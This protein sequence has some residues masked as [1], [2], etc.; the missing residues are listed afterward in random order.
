MM[1]LDLKWPVSEVDRSGPPAGTLDY[2]RINVEIRQPRVEARQAQPIKHSPASRA[3]QERDGAFRCG[4][5]A[6]ISSG[7]ILKPTELQP[8][9][10]IR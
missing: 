7:A 2:A 4:V 5:V 8:Q 1:H 10:G 6:P 9:P 3:L